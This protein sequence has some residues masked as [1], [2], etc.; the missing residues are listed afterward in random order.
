M[1][2]KGVLKIVSQK[3]AWYERVLAAIFYSAAVY[4]IVFF[5]LDNSVSFTEKYFIKSFKL[6]SFLIFIVSFGIRFS[7]VVNHHFDFTLMKYR[8]YFSVGPFGFGKWQ[9][10]KRLDRVSTFFNVREECE[11]NILDVNNK[12]YKVAV[13]EE[14]DAAVD[15]GR[16]LAKNL[17]IKFIERN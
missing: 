10:I 12:R 3:R 14:I 8:V 7:Y 4:L 17:E 5:Y 9:Y 13:F 15:F 6:L 1:T 2:R 16:D 11:V